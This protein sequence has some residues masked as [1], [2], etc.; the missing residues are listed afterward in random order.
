MSVASSS[1]S[2]IVGGGVVD[3]F[4]TFDM[5]A[6]QKCCELKLIPLKSILI[7]TYVLYVVSPESFGLLS[8]GQKIFERTVLEMDPIHSRQED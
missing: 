6:V 2:F 7:P 8:L 5:V 3:V 4:D 1:S